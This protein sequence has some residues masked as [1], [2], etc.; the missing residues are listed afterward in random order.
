MKDWI[1]IFGTLLILAIVIDGIRRKRND[2]YGKIRLSSNMKKRV[3]NVEPVEDVEPKPSYV[4]ELPNGGARVIGHR[5]PSEIV[6]GLIKRSSQAKERK[7]QERSSDNNPQT[8]PQPSRPARP[9]QQTYLNL[10]ESVPLLM[11]SVDDS[12]SAHE[13]IEP[14]FSND[15]SS[16]ADMLEDDAY[17]RENFESDEDYDEESSADRDELDSEYD[18][19][20]EDDGDYEDSE[21]TEN[22]TQNSSAQ[23]NE[24]EEVL[25]VHVMAKD[26]MLKGTELLDTVLQ[27]GMRYGSMDIFHR[28]ASSKGEGAH[29]FSMANIVKP[30]TF[31][32][33]SMD[34]FETPGVSFF[35]VLPIDADSM[36]SFDLMID[37]ARTV[38]GTLGAELKDDQ[39]SVM[40]KQTLE[41]CRERIRDYERQRLFRRPK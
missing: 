15:T 30:G 4:S 24:P 10:D 33:E 2:R 41:H 5:D 6:E 39:R 3:K 23:S 27:C 1:I 9:P 7:N 35:M 16:D 20:N 28:Y 21:E 12:K 31:D 38:A 32:L 29:L 13:R 17:E 18:E 34:Q 36:Q 40:T 19:D 22:P 25:V 14:H 26:K 11:E 8:K 37:T